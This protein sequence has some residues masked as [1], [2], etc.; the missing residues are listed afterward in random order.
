M[1]EQLSG[2]SYISLNLTTQP[3]EV[4]EM[5]HSVRYK[6]NLNILLIIKIGS[7]KSTQVFEEK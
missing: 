5:N 6:Q 2:T 4:P 7:A 1:P 3:E